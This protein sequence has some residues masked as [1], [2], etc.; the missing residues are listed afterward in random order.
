MGNNDL[1]DPEPVLTYHLDGLP[2]PK[3]Q[4]DVLEIFIHALDHD[5]PVTLKLVTTNKDVDRFLKGQLEFR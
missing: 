5:G 1:F 4:G 2:L 3:R